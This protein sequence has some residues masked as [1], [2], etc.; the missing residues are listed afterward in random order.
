MAVLCFNCFTISETLKLY[1]P[2]QHLILSSC[3]V[4]KKDR[5]LQTADVHLMDG[6]CL[7]PMTVSQS[8]SDQP[9]KFPERHLSHNLSTGWDSGDHLVNDLSIIQ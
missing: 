1:W 6:V 8:Q 4:N 2:S 7:T 9:N 3:E 5:K